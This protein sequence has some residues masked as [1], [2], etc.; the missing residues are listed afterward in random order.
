MI[1]V[2]ASIIEPSELFYDF[3]Q[4]PKINAG[5]ISKNVADCA[6]ITLGFI[7]LATVY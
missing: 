2:S 3:S 1:A 7:M 6:M 5:A 4:P